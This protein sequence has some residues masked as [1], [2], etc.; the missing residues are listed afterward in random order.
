MARNIERDEVQRLAGE[1]AQLVEVLPKEEYEEEHLPGAVN[2][3]LR[4]LE[5]EARDV[6][7]RGRPIIVYCW[8]DP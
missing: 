8:D 4:R 7:D 5:A 2:L 6:L 3:P 1:G